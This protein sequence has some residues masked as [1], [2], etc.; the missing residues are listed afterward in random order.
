MSDLSAVPAVPAPDAEALRL[1]QRDNRRLIG[2]LADCRSTK[3]DLVEA[4][5]YAVGEALRQLRFEPVTLGAER[6]GRKGDDEVAVV[7]LSDW[8]LAKVTPT[9]NTEVARNRIA[10]LANR[11][12]RLTNIQRADHPVRHLVVFILGDLVEGEMIFPGQAHRIDSSLFHQVMI[13]GPS[14]LG[15]FLREMLVLF[16]S[17]EVHAVIGNHG[18]IGK[19]GDFRPETNSDAMLYEVTRQVLEASG[20]KRLLWTPNYVTGEEKWYEIVTVNGK[21]WMLVHG[22]QFFGGSGISGYPYPNAN[23]KVLRWANGGIPET[24]QGEPIHYVVAGHHH[25]AINIP[26]GRIKLWVSGST[27]SDNTYASQ[28]F[29]SMSDPSQ[30]LLFVG[31]TGQVGAQYQVRL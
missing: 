19:R 15:G 29:A 30:W 2:N 27:E 28:D 20:Q 6:D 3:A 17:V 26:I 31:E 16:E 18:R 25:Q 7:V 23:S 5:H 22:N 21:R 10:R 14:I 1:L 9:Y 12:E 24:R 8:Q 11:V 13:D 4:T